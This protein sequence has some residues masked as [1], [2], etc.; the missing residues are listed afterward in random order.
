MS[1]C[2]AGHG[3]RARAGR[4]SRARPPTVRAD[5]R[6]LDAYLGDGGRRGRAT[7]PRRTSAPAAAD[8]RPRDAAAGPPCAAERR[9]CSSITRRRRG[10]R[11]RRHPQGRLLRRARG[12]DHLHRRPQRR[13]QVDAARDGQRPAAPARA[14]RSACA[15]S[16]SPA[17]RRGQILARGVSLVPQAHSLFPQ[18]TV[19]ENVEM[20]AF[21]IRDQGARRGAPGG[22]RGALPDRRASAPAR[23]PAACPAASSGSSSSRAA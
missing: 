2:D 16:R 14:A 6:V 15:A 13:R 7:R 3:A 20:G 19:H 5:P 22:G 9:R 8:V 4:S 17:S 10:L 1:L 21:T 12:R 23:R 18:M 11:R